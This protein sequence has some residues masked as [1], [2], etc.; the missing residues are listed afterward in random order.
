MFMTTDSLD[1]PAE[2]ALSQC[3]ALA[4][5]ESC[6]IV[7]DKKREPIAVALYEAAAA[8]TDEVMLA[9]YPVGDQH[10]EEPPAPIAAALAGADV[11]LAPT[12][13]SLSHTTAR[14]DAIEAGA[15]M[16]TL[17]GITEEVFQVGLEADYEAIGSACRQLVDQ[18]TDTDMIRI[19][20]PQGTDLTVQTGERSWREDTGLVHGPGAFSNLPA[21]EVFLSPT[22]GEGRVVVDG[23][24]MPHGRL[25]PDQRVAFEVADGQVTT[26]EDDALT[27]EL[28]TAAEAVGDAAYNLAEVGIGTNGGVTELLGSVLLDE[29]AAGTV[30]VA[31]GDDHGIGG[32]VV[33]PVHLDGILTDPTVYA[34]GELIEL[35]DDGR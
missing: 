12:T 15:R 35:P 23:T 9:Q 8:I 20:T 32:D 22:T 10:G 14:V 33:A 31:I 19:T 2:R 21:G 34:D 30:H 29:K 1:R 25:G 18:V 13:K 26:V 7:T 28:A 6:A 27:A 16:A 3:L 4:P 17:P 5:D 24:M 11:A